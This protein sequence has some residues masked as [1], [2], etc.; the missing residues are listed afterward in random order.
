MKL[1]EMLSRLETDGW[2]ILPG[3]VPADEVD[4][5]RRRVEAAVEKFGRVDRD[6]GFGGLKGLIA[7]DQA[8]C[9][10]LAEPRLVAL[11]EALFGPH[12]RISFTS[13]QVNYPGIRRGEWHADWPF[14]QK[15]AGHIPAPYPD[16]VFHL[17]TLWMLSPFS[18][19]NGGTLILPGSHRRRDNPSGDNGVDARAPQP[20]EMQACGEAGSALVFDSRL[21]HSVAPNTTG[22]SRVSVAVRYAPWWLNLDILMPGSDERKRMVEEPGRHDN[23]VQPLTAEVY[24]ALPERVRPL[25]RHWV[26]PRP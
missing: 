16:A 15:A 9:P 24:A 12:H 1:A 5:L 23:N 14:N 10:Y 19:D 11:A 22:R 20:G 18:A 2:F 26:R 21:W 6:Y 3:V 4:G 7:F 8:L 25:L 17:T 13:G